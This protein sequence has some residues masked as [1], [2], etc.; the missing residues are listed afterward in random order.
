MQKRIVRVIMYRSRY[1]HTQD[2]FINLKLLN[3]DNINKYFSS[4]FVYKSI[5]NLAYPLNYFTSANHHNRNLRNS[6][7]LQPPFA[8]STQSQSSPSYY[9]CDIWN[10]IPLDTRNIPNLNTFRLSVKRYLLLQ[11][12]TNANWLPDCSAWLNFLSEFKFEFW[13]IFLCLKLTSSYLICTHIFIEL[14]TETLI[15]TCNF[16]ITL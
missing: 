12:S 4:I 3:I 15:K 6:N 16:K 2:D 11:Y 7:N 1:A 9:T 13:F 5:N 10:N 8:R 14:S